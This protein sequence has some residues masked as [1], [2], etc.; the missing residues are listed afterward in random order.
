MHV[1]YPVCCG[2]DVHKNSVTACLRITGASGKVER[3]MCVFSTAT[4][5][6]LELVDWLQAAGCRHVAMES[7]GVYWRPVYNLI[8]SACEKVVL[9]NAQH[10]RQVPGRKTDMKDAEWIAELLAH[11]LLRSS[12]IPPEPIRD[13][14]DLTRY[15]SQLVKQRADQCNRIQKLLEC[16]NIKLASVATDILGVSGLAILDALAAGETDVEKMAEMAKGA[17]RKKIPELR[18]ALN[19]RLTTTQRWL[20][21]EQL[22]HVRA[23]DQRIARL[24][25]KIEELCL[26]FAHQIGQLKAIPGVSERIAQIVI[27]EIGAD[28][29]EFPSASHLASWAGMCPGNHESAGKRQSGKRRRGSHWLRAALTEAG[30]AASH[31]KNNYLSARYHQIR[32][33]RG[34]RRACVAVGHSILIAMY[35]LLATPDKRYQDLGSDYFDHH[36]KTRLATHLLK[37]LGKLGFKVTIETAA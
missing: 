36:H 24:S 10:M 28:M 9:V 8:E 5:G 35:H 16:G 17:L 21:A 26:P 18:E 20:L 4:V 31:T 37:R 2:L 34:A 22:A 6:L 11:G 1:M 27:A 30:W 15:R 33:R 23:F 29:S 25:G 7:T 3:Q 13:L 32:R 12:F 19:G 14:R